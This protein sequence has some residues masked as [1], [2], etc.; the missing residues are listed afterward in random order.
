MGL[1]V[2]NPQQFL[3]D[4][5]IAVAA[6]QKV[7]E[8]LK[9][10]REQEKQVSLSLDKAR[11]EMQDKIQKTL[12]ARGDEITETYDKQLSQVDARLKKAQDER[13]HARKE[14]VKGRIQKETEPLIT[15]NKELK[16]QL[17]AILKKEHVP[18]ICNS[19]VF[20]TLFRPSGFGEFFTC[21]LTF[22]FFFAALPFGL[23]YLIP[24][25]KIW[26]LVAIYVVDILLLGGIY[27]MLM[28]ATIGKHSAVIRDGR[29]IKNQIRS[30]MKKVKSLTKSIRTDANES[31]YHLEAYDDEIAKAQQERNDVISRKQSAQNT[32][33][34]VTKNIITDEIE[35]AARPQL[36][37]L[38]KNFKAA[39][40]LRQH[41][42]TQEKEQA[43]NLS[44]T[45]EQYLGKAHM[46]AQDID[47]IAEMLQKGSATSI[48]DAVAQLE[49][50]A[51]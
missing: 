32:F 17:A 25:H 8:S 20:Y 26:Q 35:A 22:V 9:S 18:S 6:Y 28:N 27:V 13:E 10:Q 41:F 51:Q 44:R 50:P 14:G 29:K 1:E 23:Y 15:E 7:S 21:I 46:N 38:Q 12:K 30:N 40:E 19:N 47:R 34:T 39:T 31:D 4:A 33:D 16:R 36:E 37:E 43:L 2:E 48:I 45:Y 49:H 11:K 42:E 3:E 5:K 24:N